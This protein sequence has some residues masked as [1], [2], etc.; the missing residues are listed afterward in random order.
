MQNG[1]EC[2]QVQASTVRTAPDA[3]HQTAN[4][5]AWPFPRPSALLRLTQILRPLSPQVS[6]RSRRWLAALLA[7]ERGEVVGG[8]ELVGG[9]L[10]AGGL[11][12]RRLRLDL[13]GAGRLEHGLVLFALLGQQLSLSNQRAGERFR[14]VRRRI[15][16]V[17]GADQ[18]SPGVVGHVLHDVVHDL[19][20]D[21]RH[22][23]R[24]QVVRERVLRTQCQS[25]CRPGDYVAL[26]G[27]PGSARAP[28]RARG[29]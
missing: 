21:T 8:V 4:S 10:L 5:S 18:G 22:V 29:L 14:E 27:L 28:R 19:V 2:I 11:L 1:K 25:F 23:V 7:A 24:E 12:R 16:G 20:Q 26:R 3:H 17:Y 13:R 9:L 15:G 6:T